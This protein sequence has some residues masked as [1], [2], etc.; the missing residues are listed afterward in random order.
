MT[1]RSSDVNLFTRF[2]GAGRSWKRPRLCG[3]TVSEALR[4]T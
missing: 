3:V 1:A 2:R 4:D